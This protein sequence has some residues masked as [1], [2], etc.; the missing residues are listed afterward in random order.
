MEK[1]INLSI[2]IVTYN[3][4]RNI[5]QCIDSVKDIADEIVIIDGGSMDRTVAIAKG[6]GARI[7]QTDNPPMFHINKQ[8]ALDA[9]RGEWILQ[10]DADEVVTEELQKEILHII[11]ERRTTN[12]HPINGYYI[13]R[14]NYFWGHFMRKGGQYPDYVIRLVKRGYAKFPCKTVHEQIEVEGAV[15]YLK[16]PLLHYSYRTK[17]DYWKKADAYTTL[18]AQKMK[19]NHLPKTFRSWMKYMI[20]KPIQTFMTLF[21]RHRGFMDGWYG[22]VFAYWS[23][24]HH[25]IAYRKYIKSIKYQV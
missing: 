21:I 3:E 4:E 12:Q 8:K 14:K 9:C 7:M 2:A 25:P 23:A 1:K 5:E 18:S 20:I 11:H 19:E 13:P 24:L 22:F 17:E 16:E 6:F 15:G 10:L